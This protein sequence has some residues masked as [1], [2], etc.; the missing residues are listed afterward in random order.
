[1]T[2]QAGAEF[3]AITQA[4]GAVKHFDRSY[5]MSREE[6]EE[7]LGM[8]NQAPSAWNLQHWKYIAVVD[9]EAKDKL[10]PIAYGQQQIVEAAVVIALLGDLQAN[11]NA[12]AIYSESV[13]RGWM[14]EEGKNHLI[15]Q[16]EA[17]YAGMPSL[18]RD[19]AIR[20]ASLAAMLLMLAAKAKGLDTCPIGGYDALAFTQ[21]FHVPERYIPVLLLPIGKAAAPAYPS[22]RF[23]VEQT[24]VWNSF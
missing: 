6:V 20:N 19:E 10:L 8:A 3:A 23:P 5:R 22:S 16:I 11:L 7:L 4:R 1:M 24:V 13:E 17:A 12:D 2:M 18:P 21:A 9:Q 15:A 14:K